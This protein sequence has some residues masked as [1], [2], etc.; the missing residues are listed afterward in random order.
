MENQVLEIIFPNEGK[1][2]ARR[3][4]SR[5]RAR[6]TGKYP[7][8]KMGRM[9]QWESINELNAFRLLDADPAAINFHEQPLAIQFVLNGEQHVH[10][11]DILVQYRTTRELWEVKPAVHADKLECVERTRLLERLLPPLGFTYRLVLAEELAREP[12]MNTVSTILRLGRQQIHLIDRERIRQLLSATRLT[13]G[14]IKGALGANGCHRICR[15]IL[16]GAIHIDFDAR[17]EPGT[18]L[19]WNPSQSGQLW[20]R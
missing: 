11:P 15:L 8:W 6:S 4:V 13:W 19:T 14:D 12:R 20:E 2:R 5:S 7:S 18:V 10:Y 9:V 1:T 17:L 3:V 16:E